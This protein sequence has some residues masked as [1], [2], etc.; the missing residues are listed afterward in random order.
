MPL[1]SDL[2]ALPR[3]ALGLGAVL[4]VEIDTSVTLPEGGVAGRAEFHA[5]LWERAE[6]LLGID[7]GTV[8]TNGT[9]AEDV[10]TACSTLTLPPTWYQPI[11]FAVPPAPRWNPRRN[12]PR[13]PLPEAA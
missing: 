12:R 8:T 6:G 4:S 2:A 11:T 5:W 7:E 13:C 9:A 10:S 1:R 3:W